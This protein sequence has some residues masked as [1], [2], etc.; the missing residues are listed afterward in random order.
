MLS[1]KDMLNDKLGSY[2]II[3]GWIGSE[4]FVIS[5]KG[6]GEQCKVDNSVLESLLMAL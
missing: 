1:S 6:I 5:L 4:D 2:S 3:G